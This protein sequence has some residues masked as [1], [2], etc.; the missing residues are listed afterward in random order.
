MFLTIVN[1]EHVFFFW[2]HSIAAKDWIEARSKDGYKDAKVVEATLFGLKCFLTGEG[3]E[4]T[5]GAM[6]MFYSYRHIG[7]MINVITVIANN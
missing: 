4:M 1:C 5:S 2:T 6:Y 7:W 3:W